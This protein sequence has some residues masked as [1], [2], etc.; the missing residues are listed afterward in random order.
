MHHFYKDDAEKI[1]KYVN[2]L[3]EDGVSFENK[4]VP[5]RK[6]G[7]AKQTPNVIP[8][9]IVP[10]KLIHNMLK[11]NPIINPNIALFNI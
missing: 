2:L 4:F 1:R 5:N 11:I 8:V 10:N 6:N 3:Q 7:I 9:V